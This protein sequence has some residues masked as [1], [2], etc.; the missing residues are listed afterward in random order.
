MILKVITKFLDSIGRFGHTSHWY[1][2]RCPWSWLQVNSHFC[3]SEN[4]HNLRCFTAARANKLEGTF[5]GFLSATVQDIY[6]IVRRTERNDYPICNSKVKCASFDSTKDNLGRTSFRLMA[7]YFPRVSGGGSQWQANLLLRWTRY[8]ERFQM[9][10]IL[11]S[12]LTSKLYFRRNKM[13]WH[14]SSSDGRR[15]PSKYCDGWRSSSGNNMGYAS[16]FRWVFLNCWIFWQ[17]IPELGWWIWKR[18]GVPNPWPSY[19]LKMWPADTETTSEYFLLILP[20]QFISRFSAR[21]RRLPRSVSWNAEK[22]SKTQILGYCQ[23]SSHLNLK[24]DKT[25]FANYICAVVTG[26]DFSFKFCN[27]TI[28]HQ[29]HQHSLAHQNSSFLPGKYIVNDVQSPL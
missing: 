18:C 6:T 11:L 25:F 24:P 23:Y 10:K 29:T 16:D 22:P 4:S 1:A 8:F 5:R 26:P 20:S 7:W 27:R 12:K 2:S 14:G 19:A 17:F 3:S 13:I 21:N 9:V 15:D 28:S